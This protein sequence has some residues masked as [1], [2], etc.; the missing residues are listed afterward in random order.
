M[1]AIV[2]L[3]NHSR[4]KF[5]YAAALTFILL[6]LLSF[7]E[8]T[9]ARPYLLWN[10]SESVLQI[11]AVILAGASLALAAMAVSVHK[12]KPFEDAR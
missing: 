4:F 12:L 10:P 1:G 2:W 11:T 9:L 8:Y 5:W 6:G 7:L 3:W